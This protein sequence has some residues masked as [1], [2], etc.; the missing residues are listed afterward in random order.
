LYTKW[1]STIKHFF[2]Q[3]E[4]LIQNSCVKSVYN[5]YYSSVTGLLLRG[6]FWVW[7]GD[8]NLMEYCQSFGWI[9]G[10]LVLLV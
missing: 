9:C 7:P 10:F 3:K 4:K 2:F 6:G 8:I 5:K 1:L